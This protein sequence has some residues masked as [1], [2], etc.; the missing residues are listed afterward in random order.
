[1]RIAVELHVFQKLQDSK[2]AM[3]AQQIADE[4]GSDVTFICTLYT[5]P[6]LPI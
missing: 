1:M 4:T 2:S 3:S 5:K 6:L